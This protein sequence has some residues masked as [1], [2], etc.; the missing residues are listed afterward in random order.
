MA[1]MLAENSMMD[2][3]DINPH[4]SLAQFYMNE[5]HS[6]SDSQ[7]TLTDFEVMTPTII[8][9]TME[10]PTLSLCTEIFSEDLPLPCPTTEE[11]LSNHL[12]PSQI[13]YPPACTMA[14]FAT[15]KGYGAHNEESSS[16]FIW[17]K[18]ELKTELM[19]EPLQTSFTN[20]KEGD[21]LKETVPEAKSSGQALTVRNETSPVANKRRV[22]NCAQ[23]IQMPARG[24]KKECR[25]GETHESTS[26]SPNKSKSGVG[27]I[28][29]CSKRPITKHATKKALRTTCRQD[30]SILSP[31]GSDKHAQL[32]W[33][34]PPLP[35]R[36]VAKV[37]KQAIQ[38]RKTCE[39]KAT[40][41]ARRSVQASCVQK[42]K[43][44]T[45]VREIATKVNVAQGNSR[46]RRKMSELRTSKFCHTCA[47]T[48]LSRMIPCA[49]L[50][51]DVKCRKGVCEPCFEDLN[52]DFESALKT[53][54]KWL[55]PHCTGMC[56]KLA[57]ARCHIYKRINKKNRGKRQAKA[58]KD[59]E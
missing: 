17:P 24:I 18:L 37:G 19:L 52:W 9:P 26:E 13:T 45:T 12:P 11:N 40:K 49:N 38:T 16:G 56:D 36:S 55:C 35:P 3:F 29:T 46:S 31:I 41:M 5:L 47:R 6:F 2:S 54:N 15:A 27:I 32:L 44:Q 28:A 33:P 23:T 43:P 4:D 22:G 57:K 21:E 1:L 8:A 7:E 50:L 39:Q 14:E 48:R 51:T 42:D 25:S 30:L 10:S 53:T 20:I 59:A 34:P 58:R